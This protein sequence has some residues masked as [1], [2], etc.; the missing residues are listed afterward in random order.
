MAA[1]LPSFRSSSMPKRLLR[2]ALSRLDLLEA[3][4]LDMDNLELAIGRNTVFE[5]RDVGVK[6]KKL[7]KLLQLPAALQLSRAK[8]LLLRV[9]VP[10]DFYTSPITVDVD[11]VQVTVK[12]DSAEHDIPNVQ[13][14][15]S[16]AAEAVPNTVD[17]AQSFLD[18]QPSQERKRLEDALV[19]ETQD[20]AASVTTA[21]DDG[22][23]EDDTNALGT[24]QPL[25]LPV[26][27]ADFLQGIVD[28]TQVSI[29]H[30]SFQ[31]DMRVP[32][33][34]GNTSPEPV[35]FQIALEGIQVEGVT[36][37]AAATHHETTS[38]DDPP[39]LMPKPGKRHISLAKVRA[40]IISETN[41]FSAL[42]RS[43]SVTSHSAASSSPVMTRSAPSRQSS[44]LLS[45]GSFR[46]QPMASLQESFR[47]RLSDSEQEEEHPLGD[48]EAALAIP[49][50]FEDQA[51][52]T[53][54]AQASLYGS[55]LFPEEEPVF[56]PTVDAPPFRE[57]VHE[58]EMR[59]SAP[60]I[61]HQ[62]LPTARQPDAAASFSGPDRSEEDLAESHLYTH[63]EAESMYMSAF[64]SAERDAMASAAPLALS[65]VSSRQEAVGEAPTTATEES[66]EK[67]GSPSTAT[68]RSPRSAMPGAWG[69]ESE[70]FSGRETSGLISPT[71]RG[72][73][74]PSVSGTRTS[75]RRPAHYKPETP[76]LDT[77]AGDELP[78]RDDAS[79]PRGP[80]RVVK[81]IMRLDAVSIYVPS[82]HRGAPIPGQ[83]LPVQSLAMSTCSDAPAMEQSS[84]GA[85]CDDS[86]AQDENAIEVILSP[87]TVDFD[88]SLA[89]LLAMAVD[90]LLKAVKRED[91]VVSGKRPLK[92]DEN[93]VPGFVLMA[94][95]ISLNFVSHVKGVADTYGRHL[96]PSS[97]AFD[98]DEEV[99]LNA[100]LRNLGIRV[101]PA[102]IA[103]SSSGDRA[104][105]DAVITR[106]D[107][108]RF[109][110]GYADG[111]MISFDPGRPMSTSVRDTFLTGGHDVGIKVIR[112]FTSTV[113][114]VETLPLV[115][116][117][118][119]Q[120]LDETLGWFGGLSS[121]LNMSASATTSM[122][123]S[124]NVI[125]ASSSSPPPPPPPPPPTLPE[126]RKSKPVVHFAT[127][128]IGRGGGGLGVEKQH[129]PSTAVRNKINVRIGGA[130]VEIAGRE[131]SVAAESNAVKIVGR[132]KGIG[133]ACS[134]IRF[135]GP[136]MRNS[137]LRTRG[138]H[139][140]HQTP[141]LSAEAG[142]LRLE[143]SP[144]PEDRD[145]DKLLEL[146][147]PSKSKF[148]DGDD[149]EI[150][151]DTLLRQRRKGSVLRIT[152]ETV[153]V[154]VGSP[155]RLVPALPKLV[156]ELAKLTTTVAAK[157]L[158]EDD[159]PGILTLVKLQKL[160][161]SVNVG[162]RL[163]LLE[164]QMDDLEVAQITVPSL[165]AVA[166]RGVSLRRNGTEHIIS[167]ENP[168][169]ASS[170][171][172]SS[173]E[174]GP[175]VM[176]RIIG[177]E[178]EPTVKLK[179]RHLQI[180]YRVPTVMDALGLDEELTTPHDFEA[181]LAAS[182]A[183]LADQASQPL[184]VKSR[185]TPAGQHDAG[186]RPKQ[187]KDR[188]TALDIGLRDC[189]VGLNPLNLPSKLFVVL[190]DARVQA[191]IPPPSEKTTT[192]TTTTTTVNINKASL[193]LIDD[194]A[195]AES[196]AAKGEGQRASGRR[197][198]RQS[199]S[200]A[201]PL[202]ADLCARGFVD[203]CYMSSASVVATVKP[204]Y[205]D[206]GT[207]TD[208]K[209][210]D[211]ELRDDLLVLET[212]ADSTQ[213]LI[214]LANGLKPP[215]PPSKEDKYR[216]RVVPVQDLLASI[217]AEAFGKPEGDY[218]FDQ[219]FAG[220]QE[221]AGSESTAGYGGNRFGSLADS[222]VYEES[223]V[224]EELFDATARTG[225]GEA[226]SQDTAEGFLLT[227]YASSSGEHL[228][229]DSGDRLDIHEDF[230]A[231]DEGRGENHKA[232]LWNAVKNTYDGAPDA[233]VRRSPL[234]L[235]V[236]DVHVIWNLF[237]GYDWSRTRDVIAQAVED[238]EAK[239]TERQQQRLRQQTTTTTTT[240][241]GGLDA[242]E[243]QMM[244][245]EE[246][247]I[248]DFLFNSIYIGIPMNRDPREL[249][250]D[251]NAGLNQG[252][253]D[254][255][256]E[257]E[258]VA[259]TTASSTRTATLRQQQQQHLPGQQGRHG[260]RR[261]LRLN[262]SRRHKITFELRGVNADVI[263]Y[264][265]TPSSAE[266]TA[267]TTAR[268]GQ[269]TLS[270]IDVRVQTL[271]IFDHVP[272]STWKKFATYDQDMGEREMGTNMV[273]L[274]LLN[275][276]PIPDLAAS[277]IVM[278]ATVL[279][280]RLHV[281]QD[282]L[283]FITRFFEFKD[284]QGGSSAPTAATAAAA[285]GTSG[286]TPFLQRAEVFDIPVKLDF[287]PK[288]VDY[289][290][291]RSGH[292]SEF[293]NFIVLEEAR[294]VLRHVIVYGVSGFD[295]LGKTLNDIWTP[296]VRRNQLPGVV[297]GLAPV[298]SLV[299]IG[300]GF[301]DLVEIP[302]R[303][304]RKDGRVVRSISKGAAAFA[305]TTGTE[306]VKLGAKIAVGTQYAL[307][308]AE[309]MLLAERG[310][311]HHHRIRDGDVGNDDDG[312]AF[313]DEEDLGQL[314]AE[315]QKQISLYADQP[316]GVLQGIRGGYRSLTRDVNLARDAIIAV[317]GEVLESR[318]AGGAA[319]AVLRRAPTI[320]FR[321]AV[322]VTKVI[323]Q[324]LMGATNTIDPQNRRRIDEH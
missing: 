16:S 106:I 224:G 317:P 112:S 243:E 267:A 281:D 290:G 49:Y 124:P 322:G 132:D 246:E 161:V 188:P 34:D 286:D 190:T 59:A 81:E 215:M 71:L 204:I 291:L 282:A 50:D 259:T 135:S 110:F 64:S 288:R 251:I 5:F 89:L 315:D 203:I 269:E 192:T 96:D 257:T 258:S 287:K 138:H 279:P 80:S 229:D 207:A 305:R 11:G 131:C 164:S 178:M 141:P 154:R 240:T 206:D 320:I 242:Y 176:A 147:I 111:D 231:V 13:P 39:A 210:V 24:G 301:R 94:Q 253:G 263:A 303:E 221:L 145:L 88:T 197:H 223:L 99:L 235:S 319:R 87:L 1:F 316:T 100:T 92:R 234:R 6:L 153:N 123:G 310:E 66:Q 292:T 146:I 193:L 65:G 307:Q 167:S 102:R 212:C 90:N 265:S 208:G 217:S 171:A 168:S 194:V 28:R 239:A 36:A 182:V 158:P 205:A 12:V 252:D 35:S 162:G 297:A 200:S 120:R 244:E 62:P 211:V 75:A 122:P 17:L 139:D 220:A 60:E 8:V 86:P 51:P 133:I 33:V 278:R 177:D 55:D 254:T 312:D 69:E 72:N 140:F 268:G 93:K 157:Y 260:R 248:G 219:D 79:T 249:T 255:I 115:V 318:S 198:R 85:R 150:M 10:M 18:T 214:A 321:P 311:Q 56:H 143:L 91:P 196:M 173:E 144:V 152:I 151:V 213:T 195:V 245:E 119:L 156:E 136:Y 184:F 306:L 128:S 45:Q 218:D 191:A 302:L 309:E 222:R 127:P 29:N 226:M 117:L 295:R 27:L 201:S 308:G 185:Q 165:V 52:S 148:D 199:S 155:T 82:Q 238:V 98:Q 289:A 232:K 256:T 230:F 266:S 299:N 250:R 283:D 47:D 78:E 163:G 7:D 273:H 125:T 103:A 149:G 187:D 166:V 304:Y 107:L 126:S 84:M 179:L 32:T 237:D 271:D 142:G 247:T 23:S 313:D 73:I 298:R 170:S 19:A 175:A 63:E 264:P 20:L 37:A 294:M 74:S 57:P 26:F 46:E 261:R 101:S 276:R 274:E 108:E 262:R 42:T 323:G 241:L 236:K 172:S 160:G 21:D 285:A 14:P 277:E 183:S 97:F 280:L 227:G 314:E 70:S 296:D 174:R 272:T 68:G 83:P 324:T 38:P 22:S 40:Y 105:Q 225:S 53:P 181:S 118:D 3:E 25:S 186:A 15:S 67:K 116:Q 233:L 114:D 4:A 293:M 134:H 228:T 95:E 130:L 129:R 9:T 30:V 189:L 2:Y 209:Q 104:E 48:S 41:V 43:P 76:S 31:L 113:V 137:D 121:F 44:S 169:P 159:R 77:G 54:R 216:T 275:V 61:G 300:S 270:S 58:R 109:R 284:E 180:D 202:V